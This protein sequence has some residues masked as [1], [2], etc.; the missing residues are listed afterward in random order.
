M[1]NRNVDQNFSKMTVEEQIKKLEKRHLN[2]KKEMREVT[3]EDK[4]WYFTATRENYLLINNL[5]MSSSH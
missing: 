4:A 2:Y 1:D 5:K 3:Q